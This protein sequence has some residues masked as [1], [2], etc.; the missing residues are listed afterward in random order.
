M[1]ILLVSDVESKYIW[2]YFDKN[3][4]SD[5]DCIISCGDLKASYLSYLVTMLNVPLYYVPGN[6][7]KEYIN[8]PPLGCINIHG[9]VV[10]H[11]G[12]RILGIGGSMK[13]SNGPFQYSEREIKKVTRKAK[14][15]LFFNKG[16]DILATHAPALNLGDGTDLCHKG[17]SEFRKL[18]DN[19][20]PKYH[21]HGHQHLNYDLQKR[22]LKYNCTNIVNA[23]N[24]TIIDYYKDQL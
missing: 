17:F 11:K 21:F 3:R 6:H 2:D 12:I 9:K 22:S 16:I 5:I 18:I 20:N 8:N 10:N 23:Y 1:K 15:K 13:Y 24:Y 7:D 19:Y 14:L 4:F